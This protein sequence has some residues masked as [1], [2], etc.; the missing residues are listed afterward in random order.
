MAGVANL[1]KHSETYP[2]AILLQLDFTNIRHVQGRWAE[3]LHPTEDDPHD[4]FNSI[5]VLW[6]E[7]DRPP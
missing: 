6:L 7:L 1:Q 2:T 5:L 4:L 3:A